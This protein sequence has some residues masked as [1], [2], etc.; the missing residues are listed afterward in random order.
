LRCAEPLAD[1][2]FEDVA[3]CSVVN[4]G[5]DREIEGNVRAA[6]VG[7]QC[8]LTHALYTWTL[9]VYGPDEL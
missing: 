2:L 7:W 6:C 1:R 3:D 5:L 8:R 9:K 4:C